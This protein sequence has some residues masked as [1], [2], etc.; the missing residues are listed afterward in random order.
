VPQLSV[1]VTAQKAI[2]LKTIP[3]MTIEATP[4]HEAG[5][6]CQVVFDA[7]C[8]VPLGFDSQRIID[9]ESPR[10]SWSVSFGREVPIFP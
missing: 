10:F 2:I 9:S 3:T 6:L 5:L 7:F 8:Q 1:R 4:T